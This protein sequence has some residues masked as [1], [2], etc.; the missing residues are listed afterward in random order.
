VPTTSSRGGRASGTISSAPTRSSTAPPT[1]CA[2]GSGSARALALLRPSP[3]EPEL[4]GAESRY[5]IGDWVRVASAAAIRRTLDNN[6]S[7]RGLRFM[8]AQWDTCGGVYR[9]YRSVRRI[10]DDAGHFRRVSR[11]VLL[12]GVTCDSG[13]ATLGCGRHC[14]LWYRDEWLQP[15]APAVAPPRAEPP[16]FARVRPLSTIERTLDHA[17]RRDGVT[18]LPEM[19]RWAGRRLPIARETADVVEL[20]LRRPTRTPLFV[21]DGV[22]CAGDAQADRG[23]CDRACALLWHGDWLDLDSA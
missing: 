9:V 10:R 19:A 13:E 6:D 11:T 15:A 3:A 5:R 17:G 21:L 7:L 1:A 16:R 23:G 12:D 14:P 22:W 18:F 2:W 4:R 20:E 8:A